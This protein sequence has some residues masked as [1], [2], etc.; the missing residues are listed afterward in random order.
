MKHIEKLPE[1]D[2]FIN[3][4]EN[5]RH[6]NGREPTYKD[7]MGTDEWHNLRNILLNEQGFICCYCMKSVGDWDEDAN[8]W[9]SHIEHFIPRNIGNVQPHS[10]RAQN[11]QLNYD[12]LFISCN[13]KRCCKDHCGHYK[14]SE[15]SPMILSPTNPD[16]EEAFKY[17][18]LD[19]EIIGTS[20]EAMTSARVLNL[21]TLELKRHRRTAIYYSE[22]FDDDFEEKRE[23]L[24]EFY[25]SRN[26]AGAYIPFCMA[27]VSVMKEWAV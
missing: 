14:K 4:K 13:G 17:N 25:S 8:D 9:D 10:Y 24:I 21:N 5:F 2:F 6:S 11:V 7:F 3:W 22:L 12:N 18:P 23:Q 16:V 20:A 1:P 19:G 27:I 15:D 26:E